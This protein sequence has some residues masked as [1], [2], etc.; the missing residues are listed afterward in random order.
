ME[1]LSYSLTMST[2][3]SIL[4]KLVRLVWII[5]IIAAVLSF[6]TLHI[7]VTKIKE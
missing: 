5:N 7:F 6:I 2:K 4:K 1:A 3:W